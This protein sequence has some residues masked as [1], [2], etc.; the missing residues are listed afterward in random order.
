MCM[1]KAKKYLFDPASSCIQEL[2]ELTLRLV[3]GLFMLT[4]GWAKLSSFSEKA[5][6]FPDPL[7]IGSAMSLG[8]ATFAEFFCALLV[9]IGLFTRLASLNVLITM[10]VAGI[11]F[12]FPDPFAKKE[13][14]LLYAAGFLYFS[15]V[16][17][18]RYSLDQWI[19]KKWCQKD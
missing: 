8:M 11:V 14:A 13:L 16:G 6:M 18:N 9:T 19:I 12:H 1:K 15:I 4:H 7:G 17:G 2:A 3:L 10:A 5:E